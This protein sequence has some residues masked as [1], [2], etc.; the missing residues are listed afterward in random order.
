[1]SELSAFHQFILIMV[2]AIVLAFAIAL[3]LVR[4]PGLSMSRVLLTAVLSTIIVHAYLMLF[5]GGLDQFV[6]VSLVMMLLYGFLGGLLLD[7]MRSKLRKPP[8]EGDS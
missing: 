5:G 7:W 8:G 2:V 1:M 4:S 3:A 6:L